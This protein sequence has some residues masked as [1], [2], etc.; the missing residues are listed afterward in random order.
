MTRNETERR[1]RDL[2]WVVEGLPE[3]VKILT[4]STADE[5]WSVTLDD[6]IEEAAWRFGAA[7]TTTDVP[8]LWI[9]VLSFVV[10]GVEVREVR[11]TVENGE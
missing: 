1:L 7:V 2:L 3:D 5:P 10:E 11:E 6:G 8:K 9:R 4:V